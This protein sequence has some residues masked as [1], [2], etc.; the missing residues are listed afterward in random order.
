MSQT[1]AAV[2]GAERFVVEIET[3]AALRWVQAERPRFSC[4]RKTMERVPLRGST[5]VLHL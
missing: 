1:E 4:S 3:T 2:V 5:G